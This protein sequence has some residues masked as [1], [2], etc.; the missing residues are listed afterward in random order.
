MQQAGLQGKLDELGLTEI[1]QIMGISRQTGLL[2]LKSL[3]KEA[4]LYF[5]DGLLV[6]AS[7]TGFQQNLGELLIRKGAVSHDIIQQAL[8]IQQQEQFRQRI[9][10]IL[11]QRFE[12]DQH[13]I[14]ETVKEQIKNI[15][16]TLAVW[17]K[18]SFECIHQDVELVDGAS[19]DPVQ[20]V[21]WLE[22]NPLGLASV[23]EQ[24]QKTVSVPA[25]QE[26]KHDTVLDDVVS[27]DRPPL[28]IIDDDPAICT[29]LDRELSDRFM[30]TTAT[31]LEKA[32]N[33]IQRLATGAIKP[34]LLVDL[35]IPLPDG[36]GVM[37]GRELIRRMGR[38]AKRFK[39]IAMTDF[40]HAE[41]KE[42]LLAA[43]HD[44]LIKPRQGS[45]K[46]EVISSEF[47]E[48]LQTALI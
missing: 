36:S 6:R 39:I 19:I 9:G 21:T 47:I 13:L 2:V 3:G 12:L 1:L 4:V 30:V 48:Q 34:V 40:N 22:K 11:H 20:L 42:E 32:V 38:T 7:S 15:L 27:K 24:P 10:T 45:V 43:G 23:S 35:I 26:I 5:K 18:G 17:N 31:D 14:E 28:L 29:L 16:Q 44:Y 25:P 33:E 46:N 8:V 41:A 37:G